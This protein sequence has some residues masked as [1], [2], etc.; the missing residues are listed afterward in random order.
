MQKRGAGS[1]LWWRG[2][3]SYKDG[4]VYLSGLFDHPNAVDGKIAE[5]R[6]IMAA[7]IDRPLLDSE[8]VHHKN[9][10]RDDNRPEN[11][12]LWATSQP[13]GQ[14]VVDKV[15]WA[16]EFLATYDRDWLAAYEA[17]IS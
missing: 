7:L 4:Y 2:G 10:V 1:P 15:A 17:V 8:T 12:E 16:K 13:A 6:L 11:L 5:H 3:R 14:R 9:G